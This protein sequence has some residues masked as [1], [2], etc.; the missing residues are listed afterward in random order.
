MSGKILEYLN[1]LEKV[2]DNISDED[3][4]KLVL[5]S[6]ITEKDADQFA[7]IERALLDK[8]SPLWNPTTPKKN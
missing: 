4:A 3:L 2:I 5:N 1:E 7:I 8:T 6:G